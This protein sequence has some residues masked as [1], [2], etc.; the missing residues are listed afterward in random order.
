LNRGRNIPA[1]A[2]RYAEAAADAYNNQGKMLGEA[3]QGASY[4]LGYFT[5]RN[6]TRYPQGQRDRRSSPYLVGQPENG[7]YGFI[8]SSPEFIGGDGDMTS[9]WYTGHDSIGSNI[10]AQN[11]GTGV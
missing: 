6:A 9:V 3:A 5:S 8:G 11:P 1:D 2:V 7:V 4:A 10:G